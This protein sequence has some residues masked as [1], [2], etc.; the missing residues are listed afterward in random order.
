LQVKI[1]NR[2]QESL[3]TTADTQLPTL[4]GQEAKTTYANTMVS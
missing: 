4:T 1:T 2:Y 3:Q